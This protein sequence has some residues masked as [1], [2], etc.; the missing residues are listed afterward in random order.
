MREIKKFYKLVKKI[1]KGN[2]SCG[3]IKIYFISDQHMRKLNKQ[4]RGLDRTTDV[5]SFEIGDR[6]NLGEIV[7]SRAQPKAQ[8]K[9]LVIHG[10]LHLLGYDHKKAKERKVMRSLE[11][12]Y[13]KW[14]V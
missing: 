8:V 2:K 1:R 10:V 6:D 9:R 3:D 12:K 5:L 11:E 4:F 7:I 14:V 13:L